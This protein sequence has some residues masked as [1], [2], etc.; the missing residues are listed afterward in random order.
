MEERGDGTL[1]ITHQGHVLAYARIAARPGRP[2][3][4]QPESRRHRPVTPARTHP[5]RKRALPPQE[6]LAAGPIT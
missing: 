4:P 1:L 2:T 3:V 5:W 6:L